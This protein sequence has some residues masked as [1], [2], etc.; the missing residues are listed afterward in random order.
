[1]QD[2]T[3][4]GGRGDA[5]TYS[6]QDPQGASGVAGLNAGIEDEQRGVNGRKSTA[7]VSTIAR[8]CLMVCSSSARYPQSSKTTP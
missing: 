6:V 2:V 7:Y 1:M 5:E 3:G 4:R 8:Y